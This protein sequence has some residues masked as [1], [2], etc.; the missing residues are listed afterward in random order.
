[1]R[2]KAKHLCVAKS[3]DG[4]R[5]RNPISD[6]ASRVESRILFLSFVRSFVLEISGNAIVQHAG[7]RASE[8]DSTEQTPPRA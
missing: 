3:H 4:T 7:G 2:L 1:M 5:K 8:R 6:S